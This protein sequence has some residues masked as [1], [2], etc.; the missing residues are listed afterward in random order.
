[1]VNPEGT[2]SYLVYVNSGTVEIEFD[3][4]LKVKSFKSSED[5][6]YGWI[7]RGYH[8]KEASTTLVGSCISKGNMCLVCRI[9]ICKLNPNFPYE[10]VQKIRNLKI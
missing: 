9:N 4:C 2:N 3:P 5:P 8:Q 7:S 6:I 10:A 1:M